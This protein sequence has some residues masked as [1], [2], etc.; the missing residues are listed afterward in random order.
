MVGAAA[1]SYFLIRA[2]ALCLSSQNAQDAPTTAHAVP[3]PRVARGRLCI[4][5]Y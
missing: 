2:T 3:L 4:T 1:Q 5:A